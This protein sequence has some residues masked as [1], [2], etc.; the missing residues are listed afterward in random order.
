LATDLARDTGT[1]AELTALVE[2]IFRRALATYGPQAGELSAIA[3]YEDLT[4]TPLRFA[5]ATPEPVP[6]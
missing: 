6:A 5:A 1:P 3:L 4:K 2:Q